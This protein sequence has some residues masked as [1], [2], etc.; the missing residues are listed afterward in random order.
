MSSIPQPSDQAAASPLSFSQRPT[1]VPSVVVNVVTVGLNDSSATSIDPLST[2]AASAGVQL[3][4]AS[5]KQCECQCLCPASAFPTYGTM[6][7][8]PTLSTFR[9][10]ASLVTAGQS[11]PS[12]ML[13]VSSSS[14]EESSA[15]LAATGSTTIPTF[16]VSSAN[17]TSTPTQHA[18]TPLS[19]NTYSLMEEVTIALNA[20]EIKPTSNLF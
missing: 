4:N 10:V 12:L 18:G 11:D 20:R 15:L 7:A 8:S 5:L 6:V 19:I 13:S 14:L 9:T 2:T 1:S 3:V 17:P 16:A